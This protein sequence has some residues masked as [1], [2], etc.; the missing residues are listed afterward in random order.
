MVRE[1]LVIT[2]GV[3]RNRVD[4]VGFWKNRTVTKDVEYED[5]T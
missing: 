4:P 1:R 5:N 3:D 2:S